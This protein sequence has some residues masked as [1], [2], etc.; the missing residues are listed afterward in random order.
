M[1]PPG[2]GKGTQAKRI[3]QEYK[4]P[5]ISTG[6]ILREAIK[7]QTE[8][9]LSAKK[10]MDA[11]NLVP[12]EVVIGIIK[13]R[14]KQADCKNGFLLDGFPRTIPQAEE[15]DKILVE[16]SFRLDSVVNLAV[17]DDELVK[18]LLERAQIEGRADDNEET[19]KTRL[20]NY[21]DKTLPLLEY[22]KSKGLLAAIDGHGTIDEITNKIKKELN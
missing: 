18:R 13:D 5:Q 14:L 4:I 3:C 12:D 2:A 11:G 20:K 9:G 15:L 19:I 22:Y 21:N 6:D 7:N 8:L 17:P 10:F 16:L 1:G